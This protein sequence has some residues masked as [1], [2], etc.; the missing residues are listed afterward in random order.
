[1]QE[2]YYRKSQRVGLSN[3]LILPYVKLQSKLRTCPR[4]MKKIE[5]A[6][7]WLYR[8]TFNAATIHGDCKMEIG[9]KIP[10]QLT[11]Y[12]IRTKIALNS[13]AALILSICSIPLCG[14][15]ALIQPLTCLWTFVSCS[16]LF[17]RKEIFCFWEWAPPLSSGSNSALWKEAARRYLS[18]QQWR[19]WE[20]R[21][22]L[23]MR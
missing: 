11:N 18:L 7:K 1:M 14:C 3:I 12:C 15:L 20:K 5:R 19:R 6:S 22:I 17:S 8:H 23:C 10:T 13:P 21:K 2:F 9:K 4:W 16:R